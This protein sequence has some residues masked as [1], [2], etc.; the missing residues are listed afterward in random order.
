MILG[1]PK[2]RIGG[3]R[4]RSIMGKDH[5][6]YKL[7]MITHISNKG[8][9]IDPSKMR[10]FFKSIIINCYRYNTILTYQSVHSMIINI[11][12]HANILINF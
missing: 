4:E 3:G 6:F 9:I 10:F 11:Y 12:Y 7:D 2:G 5:R 8:H 1:R